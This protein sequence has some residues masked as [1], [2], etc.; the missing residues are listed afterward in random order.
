ME[1]LSISVLKANGGYAIMKRTIFCILLAGAVA[2]MAD[3][4]TYDDSSRLTAADQSNGLSHSY[5]YDDEG[6]L[7]SGLS[8]G[9]DAG[10]VNG[11]ADWWENFYF[12]ATGIN[13]LASAAGD[14]VSNLT[15][16]ALGMNPLT[17]LSGQLVTVSQQVF[18]G[19]TYKYLT[20]TRSKANASML[21]LQQS[22]DG[23]N[24]LG[25][26][27]YFAQV[28][29]AV[30][31][32]NGTEQVT[33]RSLTPLPAGNNLSYR[34]V[35]NGGSGSLTAYNNLSGTGVPAMPWWALALLL[36]SLPVVAAKFLRGRG[37]TVC[38]VLVIS[39]AMTS[40]YAEYGPGWFA[41]DN[42]AAAQAVSPGQTAPISPQTQSLTSLGDIQ[43][44]SLISGP[45]AAAV[46][47]EL[48]AV[49]TGLNNDPLA[50]FNYVRNKVRYQPYYGS[51][52]GAH[53]T[54]LDA[55]GN[56]M[57][58]ASL[59]IALLNAAGYT[60]TSY[61]YGQI[62]A[63]DT[64]A[65]GN[66][67]SH[68]LACDKSLVAWVLTTA[69]ITNLTGINYT[70]YTAWTFDHV[71]VRAV[72][73][74]TTY[75]LDPSWKTSEVVTGIDFKTISGYSRTQLLSDA[76]GTTGTDYVLSMNRT[77]VE[78][79]LAQ[80][81]STL[82]TYIKTNLPNSTIEDILGGNRIIEQSA[83]GLSAAASVLAGFSPVVSTTIPP[84]TTIPTQLQ[85]TVRVQIGTQIDATFNADSLQANRLCV[86]FSGL[87]AQLWLGDSMVVAETN[88]SG[89]TASVTLSLTHPS[90]GPSQNI[91]AYNYLRTGSYDLTYAFYPNPFS[92]GQ[93]DASNARLQTYVASGLADTTRQVLTETLHNISI[94]WVRRVALGNYAVCKEQGCYV[95][96]DH[97]LGRTGQESGYYVDMPGSIVT[98]F[99]N[100]GA[101]PNTFKATA[102]VLSA[103]EHGVIEQNNGSAA[104]S[105]VKC[106]VLANDGAQK[107]FRATASNWTTISSQLL[108]YTT[109]EKTNIA[110]YVNTAGNTVLVHQNA[111]TV[112]NQWTGYGF[113][114]LSS[115]F[116]SMRI[117]PSPGLSGGYASKKEPAS[118][119]SLSGYNSSLTEE[120]I[121]PFGV[122]PPLSAEPVD[123]ATGAYTMTS[124]D[125]SLG[126]AGSPRG[127]TF[128]RSY[129]SSRSFQS[130]ALGNGWRHSCDGKVT[131]NSDLDAAFGFRQPSDAVQTIVGTMVIP[132]F[133]DATYTAKELMT[134]IFAAN[135]VVNRIT[136]NAANVQLGEQRLTYLGQPDGSWNPPPGST[137]ALTG[138][139]GSFV[140]Q[141]R[142][143]GNVTFNAQ[144]R[145]SQ[146]KDVDNNTQ[147]YLYDAN[148][149]LATVTDSQ[150]RVLTFTYVSASSP[151]IQTVSD[152]TGR[153]VTFSYT[154]NNLT[155][156]Q[157]T[158][159]YNTTLVYDSR[160][161][162]TDWKDHSSA[163]VT[164]N[165]Y[166]SQDRV[167]QQLSQGVA[168]RIW[169]F[170]YS[171]GAT[172]EV[173]PL[174]NVTTHL[175]DSRN[176][177]VG[178]I[179]AL[180][181]VS[182]VSYDGQNHVT[183]T[184]D[185]TGR[186]TQFVYDANQNL[187]QTIDNAGKITYRDFDGS[188]RLWKITD[189]TNRVTEYG[190]DGENHLTSVK[191][192]GGRITSMTYNADGRVHVITAPDTKTTTFTAYDQWANPTGVTRAD[193]TTTSAVFNA[194]GDMTS[195]TDGRGKTTSFTYDK[196]RLLKTRT[197]PLLKVSS[198]TYDS[199]GRPATAVDRNT[200]T[201]T[202]VFNNLG[203]LQS[204]A[205][206]DT[207]TVTAG[208]DLADRQTTVT[209]GLSH[210]MTTGFDAAGRATS[211]TD[212]LSIVASQTGF[213]AAG[214]VSQ[215]KNGLNKTSQ[216]FYDTA[217]RLS[218]TLDP[219]NHRV[220][221]TYDDAG[222]EL[223]LKNRLSRTFTNDYGT[224]GLPTTFT[225]P[226]GRQSRVVD[227]DL[228]GRPKTLQKPGGQQIALTYEGMGR[229]KT[230]ADSLGTITWTYDNEGNPT[231]V[232]QGTANIGRTFDD[233]GRVLSCTDTSGNTVTYTYDNEGNLATLTY[234]GNKT[235][236]YTYDGSNR[237]KTATDWASR[238]TTYTYD[239]AGRLT[240]VDRPNG[241][242]QRLEYDNANRLQH[243]YEEKG[244]T[245]LWQA[246]YGFDN[247]Y[248]LTGYT[249]TPITKTLPPPP[250][251][252]TYDTDNRL[253]TY[254]GLSVTSDTNGNLLSAPV[255]G[256]LLG[257]L[258][259][260]VRNRL[261][262]AGGITYVYD[263]E[264]RR[265]TSTTGNQTTGYTWSRGGKLDR[266]LVKTNPDGS[267]TRYI[268]GLGLIYEETTPAGGGT[269]TTQY[270]HY[271]WQGSTVALSDAAGNVTARM[272]YS[273]YG[274][275]TVES[276]TVT[277]PFC[278]NGQFGVMT[279]NN[280]LL[281]MQARYYSPIFRRFLSED[282]S[283][284]GGG[285]NLYAYTG[286]DPV[287][288]M[289]PFGLG[290]V[291]TSFLGGL[292]DVF[293]NF[294][295]DA[296]YSAGDTVYNA[297]SS[298]AAIA[299]YGAG[300]GAQMLGIPNHLIDQGRTIEASFSPYARAGVYDASSPISLAMTLG[301]IFI[302][303]ESIV[304]KAGSAP[305]IALG[306]RMGGL[307]TFASDFG[308]QHLLDIPSTE[309]KSVFLSQVDNPTTIFHVNTAGFYG[310][311][312]EA[313][314]LNEIKSGSNTGWELQQLQNAGKLPL[315]NF[316]QDG[317]LLLNP[318]KQ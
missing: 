128:N 297:F 54:Y 25:G 30:D 95:W 79:R 190:Y 41:D 71:W 37:I 44:M 59:L 171:P 168:N 183:K 155:G 180:G 278:F 175:F 265:V 112:L 3:S 138:S 241:T 176:R 35:T 84:F 220:D 160:N 76:G 96:T 281:C 159:G 310:G 131:L 115:T 236:T 143:G 114:S 182:S 283:G 74:G 126:E 184:V 82:R 206:P 213:D 101:Q 289:D 77:A 271:N 141:P 158:E 273:P 200:K 275:R 276:G 302:A 227:R 255:S 92:N 26:D 28:G 191:D 1:F 212:P 81:A 274:E 316:Y 52:K 189:S 113:A 198:W 318:F 18:N 178:V 136:N 151:L 272:S 264:N 153:T 252:M 17:A 254:N 93:I 89:T 251:T 31:L 64:A 207:G 20:F 181:N 305:Q 256:T 218:H 120:N 243:T 245:S 123:L 80:Y 119:L 58:Q 174:N 299:S 266:L 199:N 88:G 98:I 247:A 262:T 233:L 125:L 250:A 197:D 301:G 196:R 23:V 244:V 48:Q 242:R 259:W 62:T 42:V 248:R 78:N 314:I 249:P 87:N 100:Q 288:L 222:R 290:A 192:P 204:V 150:N 148:G 140:L 22:S 137:T 165:T 116:A 146:W 268:H 246:G 300:Y 5:G 315:V 67:L 238:L 166:D 282:P 210:T 298:I 12:A 117:T 133:T 106:L 235:V 142:F 73:G 91:G 194:R 157:D 39:F 144:N 308:F 219:M 230:Q 7:L 205:A 60:N 4:F 6:N 8:S 102:F 14:G 228:A 313:M 56:D 208:Y 94:K 9:A 154:G 211:L 161:R 61:V 2:A 267:V 70:N 237:L 280:G 108:N 263:A 240:Q 285:I 15:K 19:Q 203:H 306:S 226:S 261:L 86:V 177:Q 169:K 260:D 111:N 83:A 68:W 36:I 145:V 45:T 287:N 173:D 124:T 99:T 21:S 135:W 231:N 224:D 110:G 152:G 291:G 286:G 309:W 29:A 179:D 170:L 46:T 295:R 223:T 121:S 163:Y 127:L 40:A 97:I 33:Y 10:T 232:A 307:R 107:I 202:T 34:L 104:V 75:D 51:C 130:T 13:A 122:Q 55:A 57:D 209:D 239:N 63:P 312:T 229:V 258:T 50:I 27:S 311:T 118:G 85:A 195:L 149:R 296:Y 72:I 32:G 257:A 317:K 172:R 279:E 24:W 65:D 90:T 253:A 105:T 49:A 167:I 294:F 221:H 270:F 43:S 292:A 187:R 186:Q 284:F 139:S 215:Q 109:P 147:T 303:P 47:P 201:T 156:I 129:D 193:N 217:G 216:L 188:L 16:Y 11:I 38:V 234:P 293:G 134:G 304:T 214:R 69:D 277:T 53:T 132:D 162:L 164:R 185:A 269:P 225:F 103:M 66:D